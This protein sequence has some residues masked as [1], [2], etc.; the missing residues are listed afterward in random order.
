[1]PVF[2]ADPTAEECGTRCAG[3]PL[4]IKA[5]D[6]PRPKTDEVYGCGG[7]YACRPLGGPWSYELSIKNPLGPLNPSTGGIRMT[8]YL[9]LPV[10]H[11][12]VFHVEHLSFNW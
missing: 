6:K 10:I 4:P 7:N 8:F 9:V 5:P 3:T 11:I 2:G 1:L 12:I